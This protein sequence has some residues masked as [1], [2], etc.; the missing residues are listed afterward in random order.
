M[1]YRCDTVG[2]SETGL[3]AIQVMLVLTIALKLWGSLRLA[4]RCPGNVGMYYCFKSV[5]KSETGLHA[6]QEMLVCTIAVTL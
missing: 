2:K 6:D 3:H 5:G 4:P 1:Y